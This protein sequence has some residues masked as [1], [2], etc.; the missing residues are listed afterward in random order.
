MPSLS[1]I[2]SLFFGVNM[3][4]VQRSLVFVVA[5]NLALST[6]VFYSHDFYS[7]ASIRDSLN[8][9]LSSIGVGSSLFFSHAIY[10]NYI[11]ITPVINAKN[12]VKYLLCSSSP[13]SSISTIDKLKNITHNSLCAGYQAS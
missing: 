6:L 2:K 12:V 9:I 11:I 4:Q 5:A 7:P 13:E 10:V 8:K 1:K 3:M